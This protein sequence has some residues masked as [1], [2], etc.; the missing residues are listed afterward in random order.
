M[1]RDTIEA[2]RFLERAIGTT[3]ASPVQA[4]TRAA[5]HPMMVKELL[6]AAWY[7]TEQYANNRI[8]ADHGRL[9]AWLGPMRGLK[10]DRSAGLIIAGHGL[11]QNLGEATTS[12]R[13]RSR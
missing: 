1:R 5:T 11:V 8:Q 7:G 12:W 4:V 10:Q 2:H 3:K 13:L 9:K 6:A